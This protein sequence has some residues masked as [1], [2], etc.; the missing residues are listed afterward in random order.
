MY[1]GPIEE[2]LMFER[3]S[4]DKQSFSPLI[5]LLHSNQVLIL[6]IKIMLYTLKMCND[7]CRH[8]CDTL[9][10]GYCADNHRAM[11][12]AFVMAEIK[13]CTSS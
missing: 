3:K 7:V 11:L 1:C 6:F 2:R 4:T 13:S 12:K 8:Q 9:F 5:T 10:T